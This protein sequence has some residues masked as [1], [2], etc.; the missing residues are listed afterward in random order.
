VPKS[1]FPLAIGL[2]VALDIL[3]IGP[4]TGAAMN[5]VRVIGPAIASGHW[6]HHFVYWV[7][8]L[9]GAVAAAAIYQLGVAERLARPA[10]VETDGDVVVAAK[11]AA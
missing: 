11:A 2:T 3:A 7:G 8:P 6:A 10:A 5:P 4:L 1:V 9:A